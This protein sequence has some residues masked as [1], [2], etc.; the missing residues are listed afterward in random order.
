MLHS[1]LIV[2]TNFKILQFLNR[3][4]VWA[5]NG[6]KLIIPIAFLRRVDILSWWI[7]RYGIDIE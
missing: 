2:S 4:V 1:T 5:L 3:G 7:D 6:A